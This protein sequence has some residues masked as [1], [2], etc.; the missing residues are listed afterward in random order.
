M[1]GIDSHGPVP[2]EMVKFNPELSQIVN[3]V[4]LSKD[5]LLSLDLK[6]YYCTFTPRYSN[7]STKLGTL[8]N[9]IGR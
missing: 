9:P 6:K 2:L 1:L 7:D 3:K 5:M 8:S 4:F